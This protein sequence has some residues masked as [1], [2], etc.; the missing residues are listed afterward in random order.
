MSA[1]GDDGTCL[2]SAVGEGFFVPSF[3]G[4][5][6]STHQYFSCITAGYSINSPPSSA[7]LHAT[8][9]V[10]GETVRT[11]NAMFFHVAFD[12]ASAAVQTC[13]ASPLSDSRPLLEEVLH[14]SS[15]SAG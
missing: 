12:L 13:F 4:R 1:I 14:T 15:Q 9:N 3:V 7:L 5:L 10:V 11:G 8:D 6:I 2:F